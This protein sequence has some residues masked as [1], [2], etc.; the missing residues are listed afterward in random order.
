MRQYLFLITLFSLAWVPLSG[1]IINVEQFR[2]DKDTSK[3][4][5]GQVGAG[6]NLD[7]QLNSTATIDSRLNLGVIYKEIGIQSLSHYKLVEVVQK[8]VADPV[9]DAF[10]HLRF[11]FWRREKVN[12]EVFGQ[13]QY[14]LGKGLRERQ[15]YGAAGRLVLKSHKTLLL[16]TNLGA[17]YEYEW[18]KGTVRRFP[19]ES[20]S[21]YA[22]AE[23]VKMSLN[24]TIRYKASDQVAIFFS[25]YYQAPIDRPDIPRIIGQLE[26]QAKIAGH[27]GFGVNY[28]MQYD[29]APLIQ[30]NFFVFKFRTNFLYTFG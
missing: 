30:D 27:F 3:A 5:L 12:L 7:K 10:S 17:F 25:G 23:L 8:N 19:V 13:W 24:L 18:W 21:T 11:T 26:L 4:F 15:V 2:L 14:D 28:A 29:P 9:S 16:S 1:Q 22:R 20:D 6:F